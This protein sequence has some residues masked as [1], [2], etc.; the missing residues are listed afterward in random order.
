MNRASEINKIFSRK[1]ER[2]AVRDREQALR[3]VDVDQRS[4]KLGSILL[5]LA[6]KPLGLV[7]LHVPKSVDEYVLTLTLVRME[8]PG[9][10]IAP[11]VSER[12]IQIIRQM[13]PVSLHV[14]HQDFAT[15]YSGCRELERIGHLIIFS[16]NGE[17]NLPALLDNCAWTLMTSGSTGS[18]KLVMLDQ[19][20]LIERALGEKRDFG[21]LEGEIIACF[22]NSSHDLGLNQ[23]LS[24]FFLKPPW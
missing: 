14:A 7:T 10:T 6:A 19:A 13:Y 21:L 5:R 23:I 4:E 1:S 17:S 8:L 2:I 18:P 9:L 11:D 20:N 15:L 3:F 22:L 16:G 12:Q 24:A